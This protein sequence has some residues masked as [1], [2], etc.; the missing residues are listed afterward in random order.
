MISQERVGTQGTPCCPL[1]HST[2]SSPFI[3]PREHTRTP[4]WR[5]WK[6]HLLKQCTVHDTVTTLYCQQAPSFG[7]DI[8]PRSWLSVVIKIPGCFSKRV[9]VW[10]RHPGQICP[11]ASDHHGL[12]T[13]PISADFLNHSVSSPPISW[14]VVGVL[15]QFGCWCIIQVDAAHWRWTRRYPLT[16]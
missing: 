11:L 3:T 6:L 2:T 16:M 4:W 1:S 9:E 5:G 13:I 8:K 10:P 14:C 15:A 7:W 12:L